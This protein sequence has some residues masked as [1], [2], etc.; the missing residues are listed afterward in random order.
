MSPER[1]QALAL[2]LRAARN[3]GHEKRLRRARDAFVLANLRLVVSVAKK[4]RGRGMAFLDLVQEGNLGLL[5]AIDKFDVDLGHRF[6]TYA[7][8]W[9]RQSIGRAIAD[10]AGLVRVP[11]HMVD[12]MRRIRGL[13]ARF[14][15]DMARPP[16]DAE[17]AHAAG[18]SLRA[19]RRWRETVAL[20][21][22]ASLDA[23]VGDDGGLARVDFVEGD[24]PSPEDAFAASERTT[25]ARRILA[26]LGP[27]ERRVLEQRFG[28]DEARLDDVAADL[29]RSRERARQIEAKALKRLRVHARREFAGAGG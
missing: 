3:A 27:R 29:R 22:L 28:P 21:H 13:A 18:I 25:E 14:E 19:V 6:S 9:I 20:G 10:K 23:P 1:E 26:V 11:V 16:D 12:E 8:W 7:T 4:Y 2:E 5:R 24:E 15:A 17:L